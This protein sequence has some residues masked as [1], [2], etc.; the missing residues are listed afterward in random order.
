MEY[1]ERA[2][3]FGKE[4]GNKR[5]QAVAYKNLRA[6]YIKLGDFQRAEDCLERA[7]KIQK[8]KETKS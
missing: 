6:S 4:T 1:H 7:R 2:L 5:V 8:V 3:K